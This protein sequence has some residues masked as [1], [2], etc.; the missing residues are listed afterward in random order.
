MAVPG[1]SGGLE[2]KV[3]VVVENFSG[4]TTPTPNI[5]VSEP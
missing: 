3:W 2:A 1:G 5:T 4:E